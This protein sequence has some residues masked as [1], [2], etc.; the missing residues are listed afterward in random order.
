MPKQMDIKE[1]CK[2][3]ID[4]PFGELPDTADIIQLLKEATDILAN[5]EVVEHRSG[6]GLFIGDIHGDLSSMLKALDIAEQRNALPIFMGDYVD[7]GTHQMQVV[8]HL[9]ARKILEPDSLVLLRGNHEFKE[10]NLKYGFS[11][12]VMEKYPE[13]VYWLY[14]IAFSELPLAAVLNRKVIGL[15]GGVSQ[16]IK[17]LKELE[18]LPLTEM[19]G[20]DDRLGN[21][22]NDPSEE[23][24]GFEKNVKRKVFQTFGRDVFDE[25]M[26]NNELDMM[27]RGHQ[28]IE[29]GFRYSFDNKLLSIFSSKGNEKVVEPKVAFIGGGDIEILSL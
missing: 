3:I 22:W 6:Y 27:I 4:D 12:I 28:E 21:L 15:H 9:L 13:T 18:D 23:H 16:N 14:N 5:E 11:D 29:A 25:F 10:I 19:S 2:N 20:R 7:R 24:D 1:L 17:Y 8:N 26:R